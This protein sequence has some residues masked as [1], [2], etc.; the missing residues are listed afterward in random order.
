[1]LHYNWIIGAP[2]LKLQA[3]HADNK[4]FRPAKI[5]K[6]CTATA[7]QHYLRLSKSSADNLGMK[8]KRRKDHPQG[9]FHVF[10]CLEDR[11]LM[12]RNVRC[13]AMKFNLED[14][15]K[16]CKASGPISMRPDTRERRW[17]GKPLFYQTTAPG[18]SVLKPKRDAQNKSGKDS[19]SLG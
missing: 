1:M 15:R 4:E 14:L 18:S 16:G 8:V 19:P 5:Q 7:F 10:V 2:G 17:G 11:R 3:R 13:E 12:V 6:A 9:E